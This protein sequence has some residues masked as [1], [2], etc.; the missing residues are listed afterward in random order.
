[1]PLSKKP[2][3][4]DRQDSDPKKPL[5]FSSDAFRKWDLSGQ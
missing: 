3:K 1:M 4:A 5:M 2:E